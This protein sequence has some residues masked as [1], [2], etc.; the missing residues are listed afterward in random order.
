M[1]NQILES[2]RSI[3]ALLNKYD[4]EYMLIGG[5]A[6]GF[7]GFPRATADIDFWYNPTI[8]N[9]HRII[10]SL[11]EFGVDT[12]SLKELVFDPKKTFIRVPQ[13]GFNTEF[14]PFIQGIDTFS[15]AKANAFRT[16]FEGVPVFVL[17]YTDLL[18]NKESL[19]REVDLR[20]VEELKKRNS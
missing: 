16:E 1:E 15:K 19:K 18:K 12:L 14:L 8:D 4:V 2:L 20:D 6:V 17:G 5:M 3:C 9:F 10:K 7:H 13:F 11:D